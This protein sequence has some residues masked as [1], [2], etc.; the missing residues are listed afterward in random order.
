MCQEPGVFVNNLRGDASD[1]GSHEDL[2]V[3]VAICSP[4]DFLEY[5]RA[6]RVVRVAAAGEDQLAI[7]VALHDTVGANHADGILQAVEA[8]NL[9]QNRTL[10]IN[11]VAVKNLLNEFWVKRTVLFRKRINSWIEKILR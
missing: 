10:R 1:S 5:E 11:L 2:D 8:R 9:R 4:Q 6:F 7:Q 3:R